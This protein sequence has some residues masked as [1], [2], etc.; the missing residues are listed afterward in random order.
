MASRFSVKGY[1]DSNA[2]TQL[3]PSTFPT[4]ILHILL[5]I[6]LIPW[7]IFPVSETLSLI[8]LKVSS[9]QILIAKETK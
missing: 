5:A 4:A 6:G 3:V 8:F 7:L 2:S 9:C 1:A